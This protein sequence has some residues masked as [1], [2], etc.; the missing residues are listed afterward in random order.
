MISKIL[1][2]SRVSRIEPYGNRQGN[3]GNNSGKKEGLGFADILA[4]KMNNVP[5]SSNTKAYKL[6]LS[7]L[8]HLR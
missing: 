8:N 5:Q 4:E 6:D 3:S 1:E 7:S 2:I